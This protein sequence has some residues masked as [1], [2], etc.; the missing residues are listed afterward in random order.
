MKEKYLVI[1]AGSSSL[2]FSLYEMEDNKESEIVNGL[3]EKIGKED[4]FY[5]L[6]FNGEKIEKKLYFEN[7]TRA[8]EVMLEELLN[9]N[10][11]NDISEIKGV[12]HRV[13]HGGEYYSDSILIDD[14]VMNNIKS[15]IPLGPIHIPGAIAGIE[16]MQNV[17]PNIP[18]IAV[19]DT[20]FHQTMPEYNYLYAT[21]YSWYKENS[22]RKYGFHGTSHK[23]ITEKMQEKLN[24]ENVNLIVCH[25][26]SGASICAVKH[27]K[28]YNTSMG[29]TPLD[30]LIMG[31]RCGNIDASIIEYIAK[32]RNLTIEQIT[33]I[34]N[35]ESGLFGI[36]GVNDFRD[37]SALAENGNE[38]AKTAIKMF[39]KSIENYIAQYYVALNGN[40]DG[41]VFTAGIGEN[42]C[43][44]RENIINDLSNAFNIKLDK[45]IN[46]NIARFKE[47]QEGIITTPDSK[48]PVYV[49][50]TNEEYMILKDTVNLSKEYKNIKRKVL[51]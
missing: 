36:A 51:K 44:V 11:I 46:D 8:V 43:S 12:G 49:I 15:L 2:K 48:F 31:T 20:A 14:E 27:G 10:F 18:Q 24:K 28:S 21:P 30:G 47:Y 38:K 4:S 42:V 9:Y 23:Y 50:P 17:L 33:N 39:E 26:G 45:E 1:N 41:I 7:H 13:L 6:K 35:K 3:F 25:I 19:W 16:S 37:L 32:E 40:I 34:L 5:S 22:V 29:L